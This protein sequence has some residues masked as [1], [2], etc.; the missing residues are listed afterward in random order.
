MIAF[1]GMG[2]CGGL[3]GYTPEMLAYIAPI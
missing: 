1:L 2:D 3:T